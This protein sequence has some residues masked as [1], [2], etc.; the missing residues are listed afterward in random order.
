MTTSLSRTTVRS[1]GVDLAVFDGGNRQ[2]PTVVLVHGWPDTH[3]LWGGVVDLLADDFHVVAY[4]TRG[5]G[6]SSDP[7][8]VAAFELPRLAEDFFAVADAVS[9]DEP[10]HVLAHDWGSVQLW[11]AVCEPVA[12]QR[13]ASFTSISGP[14]LDHL[15]AWVRRSLTEP[16]PQRLGAVLV[17]GLSSSYVGVFVSPAAPFLLRN[18]GDLDRW[19]EFLRRTEGFEPPP[20][21]IADTLVDDMVNGLRYYRANVRLRP[22][23][24]RE[25]R[26]SVPVLLLVPTHDRA[27]RA[28]SF[29]ETE[30]WVPNLERVDVPYGHWV[31]MAAPEVVADETTRFIR[32]LPPRP[33]A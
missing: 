17:Q 29:E 12:E 31:A 1:G 13:I 27:V 16:T 14:N 30:R 20:E 2:G 10:V 33:A 25:R 15:G 19:T 23:R 21:A 32:S 28:S 7:G 9:P 8:S 6:E 26:T 5:Q 3:H 24:P 22:R 4:D 18:L 11:E